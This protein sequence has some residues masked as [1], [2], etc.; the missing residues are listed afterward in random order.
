MNQPEVVWWGH[1]GP[2]SSLKVC[3]AWLPHVRNTVLTTG[4]GGLTLTH[5]QGSRP[6]VL[7]GTKEYCSMAGCEAPGGRGDTQSPVPCW[8]GGSPPMG[9][10][11]TGCCPCTCTEQQH[12]VLGLPGDP[13]WS[14][15][16]GSSRGLWEASAVLFTLCQ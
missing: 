3:C 7:D 10:G 16:P 2:G 1:S 15:V 14:L 8:T 6:K 13:S 4:T 11:K 5:S 9:C 12:R